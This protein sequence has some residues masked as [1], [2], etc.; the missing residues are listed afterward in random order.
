MIVSHSNQF[1]FFKPIKVAGTSVEVALWREC[2]QD[3]DLYTG[4]KLVSE[5]QDSPIDLSPKNNWCRER[6][7]NLDDSKKYLKKH[8]QNDILKK[9]ENQSEITQLRVVDPIFY[10]HTSP[11]MFLETS[12]SNQ[13]NQYRTISTVRNPF[14]M[15]VSYYWWS[16]NVEESLSSAFNQ[17]YVKNKRNLSHFSPSEYDNID[18]LRDKMFNFYNLPANYSISY[19]KS[20]S[21]ITVLEW[22]S[23]WQNEFFLHDIDYWIKFEDIENSF[24]DLCGKIDINYFELPQFKSRIRKSKINFKDYFNESLAE[25]VDKYFSHVIKKFNY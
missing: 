9:I 19:R 23:R 21:Q 15:L 17:R 24:Y 7:L 5:I 18:T 3:K 16:F 22:L 2:N 8:G 20:N 25:M 1:I 13:I 10:E 4:A 6:F 12:Y 11:Q 14:D